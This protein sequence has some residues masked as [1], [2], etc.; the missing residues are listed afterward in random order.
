MVV[1]INNYN[2]CGCRNLLLHAFLPERQF[3][4]QHQTQQLHPEGEWQGFQFQ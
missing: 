4:D 2:S 1:A 3:G